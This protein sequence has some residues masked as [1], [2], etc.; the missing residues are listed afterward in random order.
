MTGA[1]T[2][3]QGST[4]PAPDGLAAQQHNGN[5]LDPLIQPQCSLSVQLRRVT[6]AVVGR[7]AELATI[8][9]ELKDAATRMSAV[10]LEGEPGI[11]KTRLLLAAAEIATTQ[12]FTAVAITA[13]EE[14]HG[15]FLVAQSVLAAPALREA[16]SGTP[17][18]ASVQRAL[19]AI[20]GRDD[21]AMQGLASEAR[22]LRAFD[23]MAVALSTIARQ[24]PLALFIDD[25]QWADD[26]T[27]RMLRYACRANAELPIF[28]FLCVRPD[29]FASVTEAVNLVADM[30]RMGLVKRLRL[31]RFSQ[32]DTAELARQ[33]LAGKVDPASAEAMHAQSEG[34]PFIVEE[35]V[36]TYREAGLLQQIDGAWRLTRNAAKLVP[37]AV[38]TLIQRRAGRLARETREV[39]S[40]AAILGRSFSLRDLQAVRGRLDDRADAPGELGDRLA[41]AVEAGLLLSHPEGAP[42]DFTFT[43]EQVREFAIGELSQGRRRQLHRALVDLMLES[44]EPSPAGLPLIA[45]HALAAG[46]EE[47]AGRLSVEAAQA[48]LRANAA[49]E[50]L[51]LVEKALPTISSPE[52]RRR[53]LVARDDAHAA[54]RRSSE[55]LEGLA[56]LAALA[57]ALR[58]PEVQL[59]VQLRRV[60]ALRLAHDTDTAAELAR[61]LRARAAE[62][63]HRAAELRAN[64]ELGQALLGTS[65]GEGFSVVGNAE[66]LDP[67]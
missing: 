23:Q 12:G 25:V 22:Q 14:I 18:E 27:L 37:S 7:A 20:S 32:A 62:T 34:V 2:D 41:P 50:A 33:Q 47:R 64:L 65:L 28:L 31:S 40:D 8:G 59:D 11:G 61:R 29:E 13:D 5:A 57:E 60:A 46:D 44:G 24:R 58:D 54:L 16:I 43:H 19:D 10:T 21:P 66:V 63:G 42:A 35:L 26:D 45:Y 49:E 3:P 55:R 52:V 51:R 48:A 56:E 17:A 38:R 15:P 6:G 53:L 1:L 36:R 9:Q 30:E 67:A 4:P 39:L